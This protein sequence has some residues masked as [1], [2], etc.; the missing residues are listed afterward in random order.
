MERRNFFKILSAT[1]AAV[2][3]TACGTTSASNELI[4][5]LVPEGQ[6]VPGEEQ[7]HPAVCGECA[8]GC[9]T[10]VRV[11]EGRRVIDTKDGPARERLAAVKKIEGNPMD[12][13]SGGRL[14][15]RGQAVVQ[16]LYHPDR[17]RGPQKRSG[18]A[19]QF[20]TMSWEDAVTQASG[21]IGKA[22]A[23][24]PS[25]IVFLTGS[26]TG[27]RS[28]AIEKFLAAIKAPPPVVC[29][30]DAH[31]IERA[32][33]E[34]VFGWKGLPHYDLAKASYVLSVGAD[35][36]GGW[37][38]PVY[39]AR[40]FGEFRR[41]RTT[42]RGAFAHA[43]SRLSLT[44]AA[45]DRWLPIKPGT[46]PQLLQAVGAL[47]IRKRGN[48][49]PLP[50]AVAEAFTK[51]DPA[52]LL[53]MCGLKQQ[54]VQEVVDALLEAPA[55]LIIGGASITHTNSVDAVVLSHWLNMLVGGV[56]LVKE[57]PVVLAPIS[58]HRA[59]EALAKAKV[60]LIDGANPAY[61]LPGAAKALASIE[62]IISFSPFLD[63]AAVWADWILPD[64][65]YL[66]SET[67]VAP[68]VAA[69][70]SLTVSTSFVRPLYETRAVEQTLADLG[71]AMSLDYTRVTA[72]E[73]AEPLATTELP[74][75]EIARQGGV[76]QQALTKAKA[77]APKPQPLGAALPA[78]DGDAGQ[79]PL[80]FQAYLSIQFHDGRGANLPWMQELPDPASSAMWDLPVEIDP[81]TAASMKIVNGDRVS[82]AS[83]HGSLEA[84]AYV[85]PGAV[86]SVLSMAIGQGHSHYTR[87]ASGRGVNPL[88]ILAPTFDATTGAVLTGATR[89]RLTR[90]GTGQLTQY[91]PKDTEHREHTER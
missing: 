39:Y 64:H 16:A 18:D 19:G 23:T 37:T 35:F 8:A 65:H 62:T 34:R 42:M 21:A 66:E 22:A 63:D 20:T 71:A 85:H 79:F 10:L 17:L 53:G 13:V 87:Y 29:A 12:L 3:G 73:V 28:V 47:V 90:V 48:A 15:A 61:T 2:V 43:E 24:D 89:V 57:T 33:A 32:A 44:A 82:I 14:C 51:V 5:L 67:V 78:F 56:A 52:A 4:P 69:G 25:S 49:N 68:A 91:S 30:L 80:H 84:S 74:Y 50:A 27:T 11:M 45:A 77:A 88:A 7:W 46:E 55:P 1:S 70:P 38:S 59:G 31:P 9:G 26:L 41:G 86:P 76:W 58:S 72:R 83:Q 60:L 54:R 81:A 40:Q 75:S 6:I 36:L